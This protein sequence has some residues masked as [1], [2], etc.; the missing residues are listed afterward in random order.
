[1]LIP[2]GCAASTLSSLFSNPKQGKILSTR[3]ALL[4]RLRLFADDE[5]M[6]LIALPT[7]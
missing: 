4:H 3:E 5:P 2:T 6:F 1:M 7:E